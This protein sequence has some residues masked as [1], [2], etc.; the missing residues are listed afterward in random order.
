MN[1]VANIVLIAIPNTTAAPKDIRLAAPAP[2]A[3]SKGMT[4]NTKANEVIRIGRKRTCPA[5]KAESRIGLPSFRKS[6]ANSTI[7]IPFLA[8][9]AINKIIPIWVYTLT[10]TPI[11]QQPII[12]PNKAIGKP[13]IAANGL[14]GATS[15]PGVRGI[16]CRDVT[17]LGIHVS[18]D[19]L[20][21][22][23]HWIVSSSVLRTRFPERKVIRYGIPPWKP[24]TFVYVRS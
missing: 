19:R 20:S 16:R 6:R 21:S 24:D 4:P 15:P 3:K 2:V 17:R 18:I 5:S 9:K 1:I 22:N 12:A 10:G 7:K 8:D 11:T 14:V 23:G 13:M